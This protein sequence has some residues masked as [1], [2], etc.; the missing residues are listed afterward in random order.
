MGDEHDG[1]VEVIA[2]FAQEH[3]HAEAVVGRIQPRGGL[4]GDARTAGRRCQCAGDADPL[5][6]PTGEL[7]RIVAGAS[8]QAHP[9]QQPRRRVL[10]SRPA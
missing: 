6:L 1:Q 8:G 5:A 4:V 10:R 3:D 7:E 9:V 2:Q